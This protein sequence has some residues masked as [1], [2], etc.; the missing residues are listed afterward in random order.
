MNKQILEDRMVPALSRAMR[1][2]LFAFEEQDAAVQA[3]NT[4][5]L[6]ACAAA[7][8]REYVRLCEVENEERKSVPDAAQKGQC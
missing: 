6:N 4:Q 2:V 8:W 5:I 3:V 1:P 7:A